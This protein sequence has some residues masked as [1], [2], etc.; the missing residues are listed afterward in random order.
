MVV[1]RRGNILNYKHLIYTNGISQ[2]E[3]SPGENGEKTPGLN[4]LGL[5]GS[6]P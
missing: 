4:R 3:K 2:A 5:G 1:G 6:E